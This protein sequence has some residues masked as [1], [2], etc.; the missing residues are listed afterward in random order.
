MEQDDLLYHY[1]KAGFRNPEK[2]IILPQVFK[3]E[4]CGYSEMMNVGYDATTI[5]SLNFRSTRMT[6]Y[7]FM[8][9]GKEVYIWQATRVRCAYLSN[10]GH[11]Y[12]N[13]R[14]QCD[15]VIKVPN[16]T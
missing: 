3:C 12:N 6:P 1:R 9:V 10:K 13:T 15:E 14:P 5:G 16:M 8:C 7:I 2:L 11:V 4:K